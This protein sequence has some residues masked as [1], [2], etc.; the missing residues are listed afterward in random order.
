MLPNCSSLCTCALCFW[1]VRMCAVRT[2]TGEG[3]LSRHVPSVS[4]TGIRRGR[5]ASNHLSFVRVLQR[6]RQ[7]HVARR[8]FHLITI[9][10]RGSPS[11]VSSQ[12]T[13]QSRFSGL[14][15]TAVPPLHTV[16]VCVTQAWVYVTQHGHIRVSAA[17]L[18]K[19]PCHLCMLTASWAAARLAMP[20]G[21]RAG[22][23]CSDVCLALHGPPCA[24]MPFGTGSR[25][26]PHETHGHTVQ[27]CGSLCF[28]GAAA[29]LP[30]NSAPADAACWGVPAGC[31][32]ACRPVFVQA[33]AAPTFHGR[34]SGAAVRASGAADVA[35]GRC[36]GKHPIL[37]QC[38]HAAV[39]QCCAHHGCGLCN[40]SLASPHSLIWAVQPCCHCWL[41][42]PPHMLHTKDTVPASAD[43]PASCSSPHPSPCSCNN[44]WESFAPKHITPAHPSC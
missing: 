28:A 36:H 16:V 32:V 21:S 12:Q 2:A 41:C 44:P 35:C 24:W 40:L 13:S 31:P 26:R 43:T 19:Q 15:Y 9:T 5:Q 4:V 6:P 23:R 14:L 22:A 3:A 29:G 27:R 18:H 8:A 30:A 34:G 10:P 38:V 20:A 39:P 37:G 17:L 25:N 1:Y 11:A 33:S 7:A 42:K